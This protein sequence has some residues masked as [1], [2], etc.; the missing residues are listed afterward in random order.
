MTERKM[1]KSFYLTEDFEKAG[2]TKKSRVAESVPN[3]HVDVRTK[4]PKDSTPR[5]MLDNKIVSLPKTLPPAQQ[6]CRMRSKEKS[7]HWV[8]IR[9]S[10]QM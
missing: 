7:E 1:S 3:D 8:M 4:K 5:R 10:H 9:V 2:A 6:P